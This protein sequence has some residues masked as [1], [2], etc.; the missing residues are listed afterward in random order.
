MLSS[1]EIK[2][3]VFDLGADFCGIAAADR[4]CSAPK[5]FRP[6]DVYSGCKSVVVFLKRMPPEVIKAENPVPY[7]HTADLL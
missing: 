6:A 2:S 4:F 7:S 1:K 5:G 3:I